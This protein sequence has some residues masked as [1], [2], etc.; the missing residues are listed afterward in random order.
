[1]TIRNTLSTTVRSFLLAM[2]IV[3]ASYTSAFAADTDPC[4]IVNDTD[5]SIAFLYAVPMQRDDWGEDLVG[6]EIMNC[7]DYRSIRYN[8]N[9][10]LYKIKIQFAGEGA[11]TI[12][13]YNVDLLDTW[14]LSIW[15]NGSSY[16]LSA[17]ARG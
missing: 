1:M 7:G 9:N 4:E 17:N 16:E 2:F 11:E 5:M 8:P 14:R 15:F 12:T 13:W 6:T 10:S 3:A